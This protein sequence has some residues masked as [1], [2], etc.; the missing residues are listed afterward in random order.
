[1]EKKFQK[2]CA[3]PRRKHTTTQRRS[4]WV[5]VHR[6]TVGAPRNYSGYDLYFQ[7]VGPVITVGVP[8]SSTYPREDISPTLERTARVSS[9]CP[10]R[11][12][13]RPSCSRTVVLSLGAVVAPEESSPFQCVSVHLC[14][15]V[16]SRWPCNYSG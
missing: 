1:M 15:G 14:S 16:Y 11:P 8:C 5:G 2:T 4:I 9:Q 7:W 3:V 12:A 10:A 6:D 13:S